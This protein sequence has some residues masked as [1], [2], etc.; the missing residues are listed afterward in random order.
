[1]FGIMVRLSGDF[2]EVLK[3]S[4]CENYCGSM[5]LCQTHRQSKHESR[6]FFK[7]TSS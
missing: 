2:V 5:W 6:V 7:L 1:M 3:S 4:F